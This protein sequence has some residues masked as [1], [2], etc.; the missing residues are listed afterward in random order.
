VY[1]ADGDTPNAAAT[2]ALAAELPGGSRSLPVIHGIPIMA[3][4]T[5]H[6]LRSLLLDRPVAALATLHEGLPAVS[7]IPFAVHADG[8]RCRLVTHVSRLAAHTGDM[9]AVPQVGLL[10]MAADSAGAMPQALPRVSLPAVA[11]FVPPDEP[12]HAALRTC[13]LA[14]FPDAADLFLLGDFSIVALEPTSARLVAG[15]GRAV[16]LSPTAL[17][18]AFASPSGAT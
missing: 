3:D 10:V 12:E 13:Y 11:T 2:P 1:A 8:G 5:T 14:K 9:L 15:F 6:I 4:S 16:T 18:A 7:M 17:A